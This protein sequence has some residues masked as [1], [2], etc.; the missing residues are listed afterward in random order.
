M[1]QKLFIFMAAIS[2]L[3]QLTACREAGQDSPVPSDSPALPA[4][5]AKPLSTIDG[6]SVPAGFGINLFA[7]GLGPA[8]HM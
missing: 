5:G 1:H 3:C 6:I 2:L 7:E 4:N 8:R